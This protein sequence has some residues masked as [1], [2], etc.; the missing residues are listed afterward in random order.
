[1]PI[2]VM[3]H[4]TMF[5]DDPLVSSNDY[6][7]VLEHQ[8][9]RHK[10]KIQTFHQTLIMAYSTSGPAIRKSTRCRTSQKWSRVTSSGTY[11]Y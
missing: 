2:K 4:G 8:Q 11:E 6:W 5:N 7:R 1:M 10:F 9:T 3:L